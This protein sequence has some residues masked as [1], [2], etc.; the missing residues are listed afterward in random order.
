MTVTPSTPFELARSPAAGKKQSTHIHLDEVLLRCCR[1]T[2]DLRVHSSVEPPPTAVTD[3]IGQCQDPELER[4]DEAR[5]KV[6]HPRK[7]LPACACKPI[8]DVLAFDERTEAEADA[9]RRE[10]ASR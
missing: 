1:I 9:K 3:A 4:L 6:K 8:A 2:Y 10:R 7:H 5:E